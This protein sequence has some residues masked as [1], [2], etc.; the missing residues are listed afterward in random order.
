MSEPETPTASAPAPPARPRVT[1]AAW[2]VVASLLGL[3]FVGLVAVD[4]L[5][6]AKRPFQVDEVEHIHAAYSMSAGRLIYRDFRQ[7]H[8]PLLYLALQPLVDPDQPVASFERA[9]WLTGGLLALTVLLVGWC[10]G[11][12]GGGLGGVLA[13]G[14]ALGH[15]TLVERGQEV[16]ADGPMAFCFAAALALEL[17]GRDRLRRFLGQALL[18]SAAFL[19]SNK[20]VFGCFAFGCLWLMAAI[21]RRRPALVVLPMLAWSVPIALAFAVMA[22]AGNLEDFVRLNIVT[23]FGRATGTGGQSTSFGP[24]GHLLREGSRNVLFWALVVLAF[25]WIARFLFR[26]WRASRPASPAAGR[27]GLGFTAFLAV[28]LLASLWLNPFPYPYL[29]VTVLPTL[30]ILA[31]AVVGRVAGSRG[32]DLER[33]VGLALVLALLL[34]A[35]AT[36]MPRLADVASRDRE[37]QMET[38]RMVQRATGPDDAVLDL[39]GLYFRPDGHYAYL[40]TG[41]TFFR[42]HRGELQKIP[43]AM[44]ER[45]VVAFLYNY[46]IR[47]LYGEDERFLQEHFVH[48]DRNLFLLGTPLVDLGPGESRTFEVLVGKRFRH[49]GDGEIRVDGE[50][51]ESGYL[52]AGEHLI[53]RVGPAGAD[54]LILDTPPPHPWP[55]RPPVR[56][57]VNFD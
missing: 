30:A 37:H 41:Q 45:G 42:Y 34:G 57:F 52:E 54:R 7:P 19:F 53:E 15:S 11:R 25:V 21:R 33:P 4:A 23:P 28:V 6:V 46:R 13:A 35:C 2:L 24:L 14:L 36:S 8:N 16:R 10:A 55:P 29:H 22:W 3:L 20:A 1:R 18:L 31:G 50:P 5:V 48:Y 26:R 49:D 40:M 56:L 17:S 51:F 47:W 9:R 44:R 39:V 12:L 32:L 43:D 38:L 27:D